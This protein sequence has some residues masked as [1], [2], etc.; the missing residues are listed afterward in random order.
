MQCGPAD[1]DPEIVEFLETQDVCASK[2]LIQCDLGMRV[3]FDLNL[4]EPSPDTIMKYLILTLT[5]AMRYPLKVQLKLGVLM[6]KYNPA[7]G[8]RDI[9]AFGPT[10]IGGDDMCFS[11]THAEEDV[12]HIKRQMTSE[13]LHQTYQKHL[14]NGWQ[15]H[16]FT[17][18]LIDV[19]FH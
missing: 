7:T 15:F 18:L 19:Y 5:M 17:C 8:C 1:T 9:Q 14:K 16:A 2:I 4:R 13:N 11:I 3:R 6:I 12:T 10:K